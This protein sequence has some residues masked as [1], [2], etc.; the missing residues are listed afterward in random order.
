MA[1]DHTLMF[2]LPTRGALIDVH[3]RLNALD[4]VKIKHA[5][6]IAKAEGGEVQVL[7][8]D[9][10]PDEG[11]IVGGTL[12]AMLGTLGVAGLGALLLPG[13]GALVAV[14]ASALIGGLIG[15]ATGGVLAGLI[16]SGF[17]EEQIKRLSAHLQAGKVASVYQIEG[18][19][20]AVE[21]LQRDLAEFNP[22]VEIEAAAADSSSTSTTTT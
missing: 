9:V 3:D 20:D 17:Q 7:D 21:R 16:D 5:A 11:A 22:E 18:S 4:Y 13:V 12:G 19:A 8:D 1:N 6:V 10:K 2:V 14:G 15:G